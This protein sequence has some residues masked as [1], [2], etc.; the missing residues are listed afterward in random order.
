MSGIYSGV[1]ARIKTIKSLAEYVPCAVHSLNLIGAC[2]AESVDVFSTL[3]ELYIFFTI[4]TH[5]W[6][7]LMQ[8]TNS[9]IK[10]I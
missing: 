4:S 6:D 7:I 8:F 1:Q 3:Q 2:A 5:R 9:S 10:N